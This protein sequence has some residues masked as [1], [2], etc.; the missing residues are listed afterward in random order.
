MKDMLH[1]LLKYV[2]H[3]RYAVS[4]IVAFIVIMAMILGTIGCDVTTQ[5]LHN[6][7][8]TRT[9]FDRQ[10]ITAERDLTLGRIELERA[11]LAFNAEVAAFN[12]RVEMG[13]EDLEKKEAFRAEVINTIGGVITSA[14]EGTLNPT[15][16]IPIGIGLFGGLVG[17]GMG[18]DN[19]RKDRVIKNLR[20]TEA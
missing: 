1:N 9:E 18:A 19:R 3:N 10:V 13:Y 15:A 5:G 17:L 8:V 2:D 20:V 6:G 7:P 16:L 4:S 11:V 12:S 14:A